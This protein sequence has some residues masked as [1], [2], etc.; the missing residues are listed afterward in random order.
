MRMKWNTLPVLASVDVASSK[1]VESGGEKILTKANEHVPFLTGELEGTGHV[2]TDGP[3][4][5]ISYDT[6]Y[7]AKLHEHPEYN[8]RGQGRGRWLQEAVDDSAGTE[9]LEAMAGPM[10]EAL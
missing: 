8:F 7:A 1:S 2:S 4:A 9:T 10:R 5:A 6:V 3:E